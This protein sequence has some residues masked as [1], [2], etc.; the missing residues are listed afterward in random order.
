MLGS[1]SSQKILLGAYTT[2]GV[3]NQV[4]LNVCRNMLGMMKY[5]CLNCVMILANI[6]PR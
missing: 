1:R 5:V 2:G 3:F 4:N 6:A